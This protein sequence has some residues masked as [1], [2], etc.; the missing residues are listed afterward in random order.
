M[1]VD[2]RVAAHTDEL[3]PIDW[4]GNLFTTAWTWLTLS[5]GAGLSLGTMGLLTGLSG[6]FPP[7]KGMK[8]YGQARLKPGTALRK[9]DAS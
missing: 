3:K 8:S 7:R 2:A 5:V 6:R 9:N 1:S 4:P